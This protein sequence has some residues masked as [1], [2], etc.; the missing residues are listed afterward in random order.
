MSSGATRTNKATTKRTNKNF[1]PTSAGAV[2]LVE[3]FRKFDE[4]QLEGINHNITDLGE[5]RKIY[6]SHPIFYDYS[7]VTF[8]SHFR[9][10]GAEY[11]VEKTRKREGDFT[12]VTKAKG[13]ASRGVATQGGERTKARSK[14]TG[15]KYSKCFLKYFFFLLY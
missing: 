13:K 8:P 12:E 10:Y 5:I 14:C 9:R 3:Q 7:V 15:G 4:N 1:T 6:H 11:K 2:Y